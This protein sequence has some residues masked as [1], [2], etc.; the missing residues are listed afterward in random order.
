MQKIKKEMIMTFIC[1]LSWETQKMLERIYKQGKRHQTRQRAKFL[2]LP[3]F[4]CN[5]ML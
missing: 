1:D 4:V 2:A 3:L 5:V